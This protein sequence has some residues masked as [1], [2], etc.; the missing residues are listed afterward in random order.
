MV[1]LKTCVQNFTSSR[2]IAA[3][4][5]QTVSSITSSLKFFVPTLR[6]TF[7]NDCSANKYQLRERVRERQAR[8]EKNWMQAGHH[9]LHRTNKHSFIII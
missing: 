1:L 4:K 8:K 7:V 5:I 9:L 2:I 6:E 3:E